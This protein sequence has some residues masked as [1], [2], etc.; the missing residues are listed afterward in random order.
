MANVSFVDKKI[1]IFHVI[2]VLI[3][4][5]IKNRN[6]FQVPINSDFSLKRGQGFV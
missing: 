2:F 4:H 1:V 3:F 5:S 6:L